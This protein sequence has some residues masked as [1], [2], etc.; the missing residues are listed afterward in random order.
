MCLGT[1]GT[2]RVQL[3][4]TE[5]HPGK[6]AIR[7]HECEINATDCSAVKVG[8][9]VRRGWHCSWPTVKLTVSRGDG[10]N[11]CSRNGRGWHERSKSR[12]ANMIRRH[13]AERGCAS[14]AAG[15]SGV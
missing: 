12:P 3:W 2:G 5:S 13:E 8:N 6:R 1:A 11:F 4:A 10:G 7:S 15:C 14:I 9:S